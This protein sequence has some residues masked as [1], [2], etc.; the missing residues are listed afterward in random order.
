MKTLMRLLSF[1]SPFRWLIALAILLGSILVASNIGLLGM[2]AYLIAA[3]AL[4]PLLVMLTIPIYMVQFM[5]VLRAI[6]RYS[7]RMVSHN[8][9]FRLLAHLRV[10]VYSKIEPQAPAHLFRYR[11]GDVLARLVSDIDELQN[12][13]LRVVSPVLVAVVISIL[14]FALFSIFS[15]T[16]A[17]VALTFLIATGFGVPLLAALLSRGLGK[18]QLKARAELNMQVVDGIQGI[19]DILAFGRSRNHLSKVATCDAELG[20]VQRRMASISGLQMGLD[21]FLINSAMVVILILAIPMVSTRSIDGVYLGVLALIILASFEAIQPLASAFQFLGHSLAA[22]ER[23]FAVTDAQPPVVEVPDPSHIPASQS[24]YDLTFDSVFF[25]YMSEE[26][27]RAGQAHAPRS[28][29]EEEEE[30]RAGQAHAPRSSKE[31]EEEERAGQAHA[32]TEFPRRADNVLYDISFQLRPGRCVAIVGPSGAGKSTLVRLALRFWDPSRGTISLNGQNIR[33]FSLQ[34]LRSLFGVVSQETYIFNDTLRG[35]L[36]LARPQASESE[37]EEALEQAQLTEFVRQLPDGL[38]TW[39]GEQGLQLSG[40][41]RQRLAIARTLLKNA[42]ILIL[43][44]A[45]ANLDPLTEREILEALYQLMQGRTTLLIT[46]RLI[47][48]ERMDEILVLEHGRIEER[49]T[50]THLLESC[51]PYKRL[52]DLQNGIVTF[53]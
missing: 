7:E 16:L 6:S 44:E 40:G 8:A 42:P 46:H 3:A 39:V 28:S 21:D 24:G 37:L 20:H 30:E 18:R 45:T 17:W 14:S 11:S 53:T 35:N 43:D 23:L 32:P 13:Y 9:T 36:L 41:E 5:G 50:H 1:L 22:G 4:G 10:E 15:T 47:A 38:K 48:M 34:A 29:K 49:G 27:E 2:A 31:E 52:F 51:G 25:S 26:E 33:E 19:Q 12:L